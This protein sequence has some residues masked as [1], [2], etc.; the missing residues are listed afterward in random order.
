MTRGSRITNYESRSS[1]IRGNRA[2]RCLR[3]RDFTVGFRAAVAVE[4]PGGAGF[5]DLVEI[6]VGHE[7]LILV[8]AGLSNNFSAWIAE[9]TLAVKFA[10]LPWLLDAHAI[11]RGHKITVGGGMRRL[12][13][14]P[15]IFGEARHGGRRIE[16]DFR[17]VQTENSR[18]FREMA[19]VADVHAHFAKTSLEHGVTRISRLEIK[20]FPEARM[21]M[22][23]MVLAIFAEILSVGVKDGRGVEIHTCHFHFVDRHVERHAIFFRELLHARRGRTAG[24]RL[25]QAIPFLFLL[26]AE[27][28]AVEKLLQ[29]ENLHFSFGGIGDELLVLGDHLF[30]DLLKGEFRGG[31]F[32]MRLNQAATHD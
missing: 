14:F 30:L 20:L 29:A 21:A 17:A 16:Y 1:S 9:V 2:A 13:E 12:L 11:R 25:G 28:G 24:Y 23:D 18:A 10:D 4:L 6:Q 27:I 7:Q 19:V 22:R 32:T 3:A 5:L 26:R 8:A 15:E 31:P